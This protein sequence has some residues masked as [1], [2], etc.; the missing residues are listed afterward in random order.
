VGHA[1]GQGDGRAEARA[2]VLELD[3]AGWH[4]ATTTHGGREGD[5]SAISNGQTVGDDNGGRG[6]VA[7]AKRLLH[8]RSRPPVGI[9]GLVEVDL[10]RAVGVQVDDVAAIDRANGTSRAV[11]RD[12]NSNVEVA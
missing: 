1:A 10:A 12:C 4:V 7:Y 3:R 2:T 11:D 6:T 5:V 9:P 8:L